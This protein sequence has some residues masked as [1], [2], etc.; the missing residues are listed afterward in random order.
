MLLEAGA[1]VTAVYN[2]TETALLTAA[3][4]GHERVFEMLI[5]AGA[6]LIGDV[7]ANGAVAAGGR[8]GREPERLAGLHGA[9]LGRT[10]W[11]RRRGGA[12]AS[13]WGK[14]TCGK[15]KIRR[16][17]AYRCEGGA[18]PRCGDADWRRG[19]TGQRREIFGNTALIFAAERGHFGVAEA[20]IAVG[21]DI[22]AS[23][24]SKMTAL[25]WAA[26]RGHKGVVEALIAVGADV[27]AVDQ[28]CDTALVVAADGGHEDV[29]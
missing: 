24:V 15:C 28:Y 6:E 26:D 13:G 8:G 10:G 11:P 2:K 4:T 1:D 14:P 3:W 16:T 29:V 9:D 17:S 19:G 22:N 23:D 5:D 12:A 18:Y 21:A 20:L 7:H 27:N 25:M